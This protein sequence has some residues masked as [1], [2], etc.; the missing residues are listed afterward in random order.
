MSA[1]GGG[2]GVGG[3]D[4]SRSLGLR[5]PLAVG[6]DGDPVIGHYF[7]ECWYIVIFLGVQPGPFRGL[8]SLR[9]GDIRIG[10]GLLGLHS[11]GNNQ[12]EETDV[13]DESLRHSET[14]C[15]TPAI[16]RR[17]PHPFSRSLR[18]GWGFD[19]QLV[20]PNPLKS[21]RGSQRPTTN[22]QRL[23]VSVSWPFRAISTPI[24][25]GCRSWAPKLCS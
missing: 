20:T 23:F 22:N 5:L 6:A 17:V 21:N 3:L 14:P 2:G 12:T 8:Q 4:L 10:L 9:D 13:S 1:H 19:S 24:A 11:S 7:F 16:V 25:N 15:K 18:Q